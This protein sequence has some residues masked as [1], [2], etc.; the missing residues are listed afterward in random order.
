MEV[1]GRHLLSL[2]QIGYKAD[3]NGKYTH[4]V[5]TTANIDT[6]GECTAKWGLGTVRSEFGW[7]MEVAMWRTSS[8]VIS[9][10]WLSE[11]GGRSMLYLLGNNHWVRVWVGIMLGTTNQI[12]FSA[13][14]NPLFFMSCIFTPL[15]TQC[16]PRMQQ[17][18]FSH[19]KSL[20][21][22]HLCMLI[23]FN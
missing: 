21:E 7:E 14:S 17:K 12:S 6:H 9:T 22:I 8:E 11:L 19:Y 10:T 3:P 13:T 4:L 16:V 20:L 5:S 1:L 2:D 18:I 15:H 23:N